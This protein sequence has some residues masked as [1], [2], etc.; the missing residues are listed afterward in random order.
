MAYYRSSY[1]YDTAAKTKGTC[2]LDQANGA[3]HPTTGQYSYFATYGYP[4]IPYYYFGAN[5]T[6]T[7]CGA[8]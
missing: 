1:Y 7:I 4:F 6:G 3:I 8:A 5:G 2:N